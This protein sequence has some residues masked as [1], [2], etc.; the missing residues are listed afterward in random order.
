[1]IFLIFQ[2]QDLFSKKWKTYILENLKLKTEFRV[3]IIKI[4]F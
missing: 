3:I 4:D 1:M 2:I